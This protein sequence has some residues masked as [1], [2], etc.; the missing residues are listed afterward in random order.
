MAD[1]IQG[2]VNAIREV[3]AEWL[4]VEQAIKDATAAYNDQ[5]SALNKLMGVEKTIKMNVIDRFMREFELRKGIKNLEKEI[6]K[7]EV[8]SLTITGEQ[9]RAEAVLSMKGM[10]QRKLSWSKELE[11]LS[12]INKYGIGIFLSFL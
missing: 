3:A 9:E 4:N 11:L 6:S 2:D 12:K 10:Q 8:E 1:N 7:L 5:N